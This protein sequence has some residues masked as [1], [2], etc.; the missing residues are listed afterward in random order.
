[1]LA[2]NVPAMTLIGVARLAFAELKVEIDA[3][4]VK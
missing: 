4:A 2:P 1:V 3:I